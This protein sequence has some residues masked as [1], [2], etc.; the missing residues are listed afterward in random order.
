MNETSATSAVNATQ[1]LREDHR[2]VQ[3]LFRR[4]EEAE[5]GSHERTEIV[6]TAL[7]ELKVHTTIEEEIFYPAARRKTGDE[8]SVDE[9][10]EE[11]HVAKVLISE[12]EELSPK[13][14]AFAAKFT[15]LAENVKHHIEEEESEMFP[16]MEESGE[17]LSAL[18]GRL[19]ERKENLMEE[20]GARQAG[21]KG[22]RK[23]R[24]KA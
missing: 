17:D 14:E 7:Q 10:M 23:S 3:D 11:H 19:M 13:D 15:V 1:L 5:E 24:K 2:K 12:I 16:A 18:G 6:R 4:F 20:H 8:S 22:A 21:A 9:A